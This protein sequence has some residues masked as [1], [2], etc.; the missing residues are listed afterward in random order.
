M[1]AAPVGQ[2]VFSSIGGRHPD[3]R[4]QP[5]Q[6][7]VGLASAGLATAQGLGVVAAGLLASVV[8]PSV[9]VAV[10]GAAGG[11]CAIGA[12]IAWHRANGPA[13]AP[14]DPAGETL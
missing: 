2:L 10:C 4:V 9:T 6:Q 13:A 11:L 8:A 12:G 1:L 5:L 3:V 14:L 7:V